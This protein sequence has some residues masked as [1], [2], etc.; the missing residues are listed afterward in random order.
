MDLEEI[1]KKAEKATNTF[2]KKNIRN[3]SLLALIG[4]AYAASATYAGINDYLEQVQKEVPNYGD[5][6][7]MGVCTLAGLALFGIA[8]NLARAYYRDYSEIK[9]K[10]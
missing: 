1:T 6:L 7:S 8:A 10:L 5:A 2:L 3:Y 9:Q 4:L